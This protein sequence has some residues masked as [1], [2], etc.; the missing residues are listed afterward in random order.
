M[1]LGTLS[2]KRHTAGSLVKVVGSFSGV[3]NWLGDFGTWLKGINEY[4]NVALEHSVWVSP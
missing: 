3:L 2:Y 4:R 1:G